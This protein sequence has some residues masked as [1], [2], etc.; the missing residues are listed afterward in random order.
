MATD[1]AR[2][3]AINLSF[4]ASDSSYAVVRKILLFPILTRIQNGLRCGD[5]DLYLPVAH[6]THQSIKLAGR[7]GLSAFGIPKKDLIY[8]NM[9]AGHEFQKD[10]D[11]RMLPFVFNIRQIPRRE[12]QRNISFPTLLRDSLR[13]VLA[14]LTAAP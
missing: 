8:R 3:N 5:E 11:A 6:F 12:E 14:F 2:K 7:G 10:L 9:I 1:R 13:S 4:I